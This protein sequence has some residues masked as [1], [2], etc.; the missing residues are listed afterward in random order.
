MPFF[1][2]KTAPPTAGCFGK[3]P[4]AG[5][6]VSHGTDGREIESL[7]AWLEGAASG[8]RSRTVSETQVVRYLWPDEAGRG[9]L[10]GALWPSRDKAGRRFPFTT[11]TRLP[12]EVLAAAGGLLP[13]I[14]EPLWRHLVDAGSRVRAAEPGPDQFAVLREP[15]PPEPATPAEAESLLRSGGVASLD[16]GYAAGRLALEAHAFLRYCAALRAED[17]LPPFALRLRLSSASDL[18][19][20]AATWLRILEARLDRPCPPLTLF[21]RMDPMDGPLGGAAA[22]LFARDMAGAD[23][24]FIFAPADR[25]PHADSVGFQ[26]SPADGEEAAFRTRFLERR[27]GMPAVWTTLIHLAT[28]DGGGD[29]AYRGRTARD[30]APAAAEAE[31][32]TGPETEA[33]EGDVTFTLGPAAEAA[34]PARPEAGTRQFWE[35]QGAVATSIPTVPGGMVT[36]QVWEPA[37]RTEG[38][39]GRGGESADDP[40]AEAAAAAFWGEADDAVPAA[41]RAR[42]AEG[43]PPASEPATGDEPSDPEEAVRRLRQLAAGPLLAG[44]V[45][46]VDAPEG[47]SGAVHVLVLRSGDAARAVL[48]PE[49]VDVEDARSAAR[50]YAAAKALLAVVEKAHR[51]MEEALAAE[52]EE[53]AAAHRRHYIG[54]LPGA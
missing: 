47:K 46:R 9:A 24:P 5:D 28:D 15:P 45:L 22:F 27:A 12:Q 52:V 42:P 3:L 10:V 20:E 14:A 4:T 34:A 51:R 13:L 36:G 26:E 50:N 41:P 8:L 11:F 33:P 37:H 38:S 54:D 19:A 53:R 49:R 6:Y 48:L 23:L 39:E 1:Q 31:P 35:R 32:V 40:D 7:M 16:D 17:P 21:L 29:E 43:A 18:A 2:R 30:P 25:Y 44:E